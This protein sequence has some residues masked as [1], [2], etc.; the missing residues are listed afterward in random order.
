MTSP[1]YPGPAGEKGS[2]E[3]AQAPL[4]ALKELEGLRAPASALTLREQWT[5]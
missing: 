3:A 1:H 4:Q 2:P 5:H